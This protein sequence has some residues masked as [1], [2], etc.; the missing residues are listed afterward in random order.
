MCRQSVLRDTTV[1]KNELRSCP[2]NVSVDE[3]YCDWTH[4]SKIEKEFLTPIQ[5]SKQNEMDNFTTNNATLAEMIE[6]KRQFRDKVKLELSGYERELTELESIALTLHQSE[7][8][9]HPIMLTM[10]KCQS[11]VVPLLPTNSTSI[12]LYARV[13]Q[14]LRYI[15]RASGPGEI[16]AYFEI[17]SKDRLTGYR[18]QKMRTHIS[19]A[20]ERKEKLFRKIPG[21][22]K[23]ELIEWS[24]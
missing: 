23:W 5:P 2:A 13:E 4:H 6:R 17:F 24:V 19:T 1:R 9:I 20:M 22:C 16:L 15:G 7:Q 12:P 18:R 14:A 10:R 21:T 3:L 8:P 11:A